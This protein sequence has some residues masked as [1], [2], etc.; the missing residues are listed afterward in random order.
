M[1]RAPN[2]PPC[3]PISGPANKQ[4]MPVRLPVNNALLRPTS[5]FFQPQS[6]LL[7]PL[8]TRCRLLFIL[9]DPSLGPTPPR[10][11]ILLL[12]AIDCLQP[13]LHPGGLLFLPHIGTPPPNFSKRWSR[14]SHSSFRGRYWVLGP[15]GSFLQWL[16]FCK[17]RG[18][19][20]GPPGPPLEV[21]Y[22][23]EGCPV[24]IQ[25]IGF[26]EISSRREN[27]KAVEF[28]CGLSSSFTI[29]CY[30]NLRELCH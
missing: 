6:L 30:T 11:S 20:G 18:P 10:F 1:G 15:V 26:P 12:G 28:C 19:P 21:R 7:P 25:P 8:W 29:Q 13:H 3:L 23:P 14:R 4:A 5:P 2:L 17:G 24:I 22:P 9:P 27:S 16:G